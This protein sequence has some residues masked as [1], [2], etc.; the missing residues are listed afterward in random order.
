MVVHSLPV[1]IE[2]VYIYILRGLV[3]E[4][5]GRGGVGILRTDGAL[6]RA[7]LSLGRRQ[8]ACRRR[9]GSR[10][11]GDRWHRSEGRRRRGGG[12]ERGRRS[13]R[14]RRCRRVAGFGCGGTECLGL[15]RADH[16]QLGYRNAVD[17]A[18]V[19][20]RL[21]LHVD[22]LCL[23]RQGKDLDSRRRLAGGL[24]NGAEASIVLSSRRDSDGEVLQ[25]VARWL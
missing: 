21:Q 14:G 1:V 6:L 13:G 11:C 24:Q 10:G 16:A 23:V 8:G 15:I 20:L 22:G 5:N 9:R 19:V 4:P 2:P 18:L 12:S 17:S 7:A 25:A 3:D